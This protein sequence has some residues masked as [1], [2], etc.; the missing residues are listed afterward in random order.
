[1]EV[2]ALQKMPPRLGPHRRE[3]ISFLQ[4]VPHSRGSSLCGDW[5]ICSTG[6]PIHTCGAE[7]C[8]RSPLEV[9]PSSE[10]GNVEWSKCFRL[11]GKRNPRVCDCKETFCWG[12]EIRLQMLLQHLRRK[13]CVSS[14]PHITHVVFPCLLQTHGISLRCQTPPGMMVP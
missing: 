6:T 3:S 5:H 9:L 4:V 2:R 7:D 12:P 14:F 8:T 1:M 10:R 13:T 11:L